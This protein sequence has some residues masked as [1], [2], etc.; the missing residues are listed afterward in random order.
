MFT[1]MKTHFA[2]IIFPDGFAETAGISEVK[3][4]KFEKNI[5]DWTLIASEYEKEANMYK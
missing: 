4:D 2:V 5:K 1:S 3:K